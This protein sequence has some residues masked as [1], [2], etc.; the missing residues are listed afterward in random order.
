MN[1]LPVTFE[2]GI[3]GPVHLDVLKPSRQHSTVSPLHPYP[4]LSPPSVRYLTR[5]L[6]CYI[7]ISR[8]CPCTPAFFQSSTAVSEFKE[9]R[10]MT[11]MNFYFRYPARTPGVPCV[12][13]C[14]PVQS[15]HAVRRT[16]RAD[17]KLTPLYAVVLAFLKHAVKLRLGEPY[18]SWAMFEGSHSWKELPRSGER[19]VSSDL[20]F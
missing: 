13:S 4:P 15:A 14:V 20:Q 10:E 19:S 6:A 17:S 5:F 11:S 1:S 7:P 16:P 18:V 3:T 9:P 12:L 2:N 8:K